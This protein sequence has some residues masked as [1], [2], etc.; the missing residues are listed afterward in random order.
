MQVAVLFAICTL[1]WGST[2]LVIR[3]Q[4]GVV[5]P[6]VSV[7]YRFVIAAFLLLVW[8]TLSRRSLRIPR[9][10]HLPVAAGGLALYWLDYTLLYYGEEHL[11]SAVVALMSCLMIY[12]NV[13]LRRWFFNK[14]VRRDVLLGASLGVIGLVLVFRP[15]FARLSTDSLLIGGILLVIGSNFFASV[16]NVLN[17]YVLEHGVPVVQLNFWGMSYAVIAMLLAIWIGGIPLTL[18]A[19]SDFWLA[20]VYLSVFGTV[21]AFGAY[22]KLMQKIGSDRSVFVVLLFPLVALVL[23]SWFENFQWQWQTLLGIGVILLGNAT[24][25][26]KLRLMRH[27]RPA[28]QS[29]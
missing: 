18:P 29:A 20:T 2:W 17:E 28:R 24:A 13:L 4:L 26:G 23:S 9:Q 22:M 27:L 5:D 10:L 3:L 16:G 8:I 1:I 19:D 12:M 15:E 11:I 21:L 7:L 14:P 25:L 6:M